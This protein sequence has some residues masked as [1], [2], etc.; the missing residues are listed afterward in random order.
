MQICAICGLNLGL[1]EGGGLN[2][3]TEQKQAEMEALD[4]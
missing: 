1:L 3:G 4:R 2:L